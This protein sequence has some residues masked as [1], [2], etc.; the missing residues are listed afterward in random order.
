MKHKQPLS[1]LNT[2]EKRRQRLRWANRFFLAAMPLWILVSGWDFMKWSSK[3]QE[4]PAPLV[5]S[6]PEL[7][8]RLPEIP[9]WEV[10]A[11]LFRFVQAKPISQSAPSETALSQWKLLGVSLG[12]S[13]RAFL[14]EIDSK[15]TLWVSPGDMVGP[16]QVKE[17]QERSVTLEREGTLYEIS[18]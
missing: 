9:L 18:M 3:F 12:A 1:S 11:S 15:K 16:F 8:Q 6:L 2:W 7:R 13:R 4:V 14:E 10:S 5:P 17:I